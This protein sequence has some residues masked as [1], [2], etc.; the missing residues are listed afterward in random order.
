MALK[1]KKTWL[2]LTCITIVAMLLAWIALISPK[3]YEMIGYTPSEAIVKS[4]KM[5]GKTE[6]ATALH[7][8]DY[9]DIYAQASVKGGM[10]YE[11]EPFVLQVKTVG[12]SHIH[13]NVKG[14]EYIPNDGLDV[15]YE[16]IEDIYT[17]NYSDSYDVGYM[18]ITNSPSVI[19]SFYIEVNKD[20]KVELGSYTF[21]IKKRP[22]SK[23]LH[24]RLIGLHKLRLQWLEPKTSTINI[25]YKNGV[26]YGKSEI[27]RDNDYLYIDGTFEIT[28]ANN[29]YFT[30][31]IR[32]KVSYLNNG[33]E[34]LRNGTYHFK[35]YNGRQYWRMQEMAN[36]EGNGVV[37]YIDIFF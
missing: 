20:E 12:S 1:K 22:I 17:P 23:E 18:P 25:E 24:N 4:L 35:A 8:R 31:E 11:G 33:Q 30:G 34:C 14:A 27:I 26:Y 6:L 5:K 15:V 9:G 10:I 28:D 32:E 16:Y 37:D 21:D 7:H 36:C 29:I 19:I 2:Y 13:Y 3:T